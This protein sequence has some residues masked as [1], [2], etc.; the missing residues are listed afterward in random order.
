MGIDAVVGQPVYLLIVVMISAIC[1]MFIGISLQPLLKDGQVH[2]VESQID[3]ILTE[4]SHMFEYA[5]EGSMVHLQVDFPTSLRF[6]VFGSLPRNGTTEPSNR[7]LDENTS[8][9][10]YFVMDDGTLRMFHSN[11]RFSNQNN[12]EIVVLHPG[13]YTL[14]M[15]MVHHEGKTYVTMS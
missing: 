3:V 10:Y 7:T 5:D 11:A 1:L 15:E 6:I 4:S 12:T 13:R 9:N 14:T 8:N 2:Q